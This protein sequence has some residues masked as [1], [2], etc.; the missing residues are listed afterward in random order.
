MARVRK[1]KPKLRPDYVNRRMVAEERIRR[2]VSHYKVH[3][4]ATQAAIAAGYSKK[5]AAN[6]GTILLKN[7]RVQE[8]LQEHS[9]EVQA[10]A[11]VKA[12]DILQALQEIAYLDPLDIFYPDGRCRPM[13]EIPLRA[14]RCIAGFD[15]VKQNL[16]KGDGITDEVRRVKLVPKHVALDLL[17]RHKGLTVQASDSVITAKQLEKMT[18]EE[19]L[20]TQKQAL[21]RFERHLAAKALL[22][23]RLLALPEAERA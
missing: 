20:A 13:N 19:F 2:F 1:P 11:G 17:A 16:V 7:G 6:R 14:R 15:V 21:E 22:Q 4:N 18:D 23:A 12:R 9:L 8:L 3:L 5:D 10:E